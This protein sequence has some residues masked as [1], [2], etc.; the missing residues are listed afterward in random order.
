MNTVLQRITRFLVSLPLAFLL[1]ILMIQ[2]ASARQMALVI[3]NNAYANLSEQQQLKT[4]INDA[5]AVGDK[6]RDLGFEV[7][8]RHDQNRADFVNGLYDFASKLIKD[9][10]VFVFYAGHGV[11]FSGQNYYLPTDIPAPSGNS[12]T[13]ENRIAVNAIS[14]KLLIQTMVDAGAK[15]TFAIFDA[16]RDNPLNVNNDPTRSLGS[17]SGLDVPPLTRG[18]GILYSASPGQQAL[19]RLPGENAEDGVNSIFTRVLLKELGKPG[20]SLIGM[21]RATR[22]EVERLAKTAAGHS[23][24]PGYYEDLSGDIFFSGG[25]P[26]PGT[27]T[28]QV[29]VP[30][31]V[32]Q[33]A[34]IPVS[35]DPAT[36]WAFVKDTKNKAVV[37]AFIDKYR[38]SPVY[39][40]LAEEKLA[41]LDAPEPAPPPPPK[42]EKKDSG[43]D[44]A[45]LPK[46]TR[47]IADD[48]S[49]PGARWVVVTGSYPK[50][51]TRTPVARRAKMRNAGFAAYVVD[52]NNFNALR[53]GLWA[54][55]IG[56]GSR[57][58]ADRILSSARRHVPDAY[59][60][61]LR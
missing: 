48:T 4:A 44:V 22:D 59:V 46:P 51:D 1:A 19:D 14:E 26:A 61:Q 41:S 39:R 57:S 31:P 32:P 2:P 9:D 34:P 15:V 6:L 56:A 43:T 11:N 24:R 42:S 30:N 21:A 10:V 29:P 20:Q 47:G 45:N 8:V 52:T 38:S 5:N 54:V 28:T 17:K 50:S 3:G 13:E 27:T 37:K 23:Q 25:V 16:C 7:T 55:V 36:D 35:P 33:P 12:Q 40:A 49:L 53:D 58:E 18:V 60:R